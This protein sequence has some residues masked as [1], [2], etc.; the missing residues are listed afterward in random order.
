[1]WAVQGVLTGAFSMFN[2]AKAIYSGA[3]NEENQRANYHRP[4]LK[5]TKF[6]HLCKRFRQQR[7]YSLGDQARAT[8]RS[9]GYISQLETGRKP[10]TPEYVSILSSFF[11]LNAEDLRFLK[12]T[13]DTAIRPVRVVPL[14]QDQAALASELARM[15]GKLMPEQCAEVLSALLGAGEKCLDQISESN[16][17]LQHKLNLPHV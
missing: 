2:A 6:G 12:N 8:G 5:R 17:C 11:K 4:E 16:K 15:I 3:M 1:M 7:G 13:A 9:M 10:V 14:T